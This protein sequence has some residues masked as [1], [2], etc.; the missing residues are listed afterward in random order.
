MPGKKKAPSRS[1]TAQAGRRNQRRR[2]TRRARCSDQTQQP[3]AHSIAD[4]P[5]GNQPGKSGWRR[6][7]PHPHDNAELARLAQRI[8][9]LTT[10]ATRLAGDLTGRSQSCVAG[11]ASDDLLDDAARLAITLAALRVTDAAWFM[12][13]ALSIL[14]EAGR[15]GS[16]REVAA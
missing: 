2:F 3:V 14:D 5:Q 12:C 15:V 13:D 4:L 1:T 7:A 6:T 10:R 16:A 9:Q 11:D 8:A